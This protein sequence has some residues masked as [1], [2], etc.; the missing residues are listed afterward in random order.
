MSLQ[1]G[2]YSFLLETEH[3]TS[4]YKQVT[5]RKL[6]NEGVPDALEV[7]SWGTGEAQTWFQILPLKKKKNFCLFPRDLGPDGQP[8]LKQNKGPEDP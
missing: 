3:R 6:A 8:P 5:Q 7:E 4:C 2:E 1:T